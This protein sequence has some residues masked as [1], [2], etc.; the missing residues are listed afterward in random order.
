[1]FLED[2]VMK[3]NPLQHNFDFYEQVLP[4][5]YVQKQ[6]GISCADIIGK[7]PFNVA[8]IMKYIWRH[9]GKDKKKD[10]E[11]AIQYTIMEIKSHNGVWAYINY[12][13]IDFLRKKIQKVSEYEPKAYK[14]FVY[15]KIMDYL[16]SRSADILYTILDELKRTIREEY[17]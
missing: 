12:V 16:E 14:I 11:K 15:L 4:A 7:L 17:I 10:M 13:D 6:T 1:M 3:D 8:C 9:E 5:Y 2:L